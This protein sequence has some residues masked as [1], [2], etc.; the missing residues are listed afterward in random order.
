MLSRGWRSSPQC[1]AGGRSGERTLA[2]DRSEALDV[3]MRPRSKVP[4]RFACVVLVV[5]GATTSS[6]HTFWIE[7]SPRAD[8][9][10]EVSL[11]VGDHLR[12]PE[13][14]EVQSFSRFKRFGLALDAEHTTDL[15]LLLKL[16]GSPV[17]V[18]PASM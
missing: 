10:R 6:A 17:A 18:L 3:S 2:P 9:A 7:V 13:S 11:F 1:C 4:I 14:Q 8:G 15:S 12:S 5:L 16:A